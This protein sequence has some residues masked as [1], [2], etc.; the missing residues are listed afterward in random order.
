MA[1]DVKIRHGYKIRGIA[2]NDL[3]A[4]APAVREQYWQ[5]VV[6]L[7]LKRKDKELSEGLDKDGNPLRAIKP[8]TKKHRRSAMTPSRR[9][10]PAAPPL[11]PAFQKSRTRSLLA[12]RAL[13]THAEFFWRFD[14]WTHDSWAVVL[15][16]QAAEGRDV[17]GLSPEGVA[18]VKARADLK[19]SAYK[20]GRLISEPASTTRP[21]E[22]IKG[23]RTPSENAI[24][25]MS[26]GQEP[27]STAGFTKGRTAQEWAAYFR[28]SAKAVVP[29]R[30]VNPPARSGMVGP[31]YN[32]LLQHIWGRRA[33]PKPPGERG[34]SPFSPPR[35]P[36]GPILFGPK[37]KVRTPAPQAGQPFEPALAIAERIAKSP[38]VQRTYR[39]ITK[40][41]S[42]LEKA[43]FAR[44]A[45]QDEMVAFMDARP[46]LRLAPG[47]PET[48]ALLELERKFAEK[49]DRITELRAKAHKRLDQALN[50][51]ASARVR[52]EH[53]DGAG[54]WSKDAVAS[55]T[56]KT[57]QD[58]LATKVANGKAT[59]ALDVQWNLKDG[60]RA[61]ATHTTHTSGP[62]GGPPTWTK[63]FGSITVAPTD[64]AKT[65]VHEMAHHVENST[66]G[67][68][69]AAEEFLAHR[70]GSQKLEKLKDVFPDAGYEDGE[71]GRDDEFAKA[72]GGN[73]RHAYYTGKHYAS[74]QTELISM[75]VERLYDD[76][77]A[78]AE[79]DPE[80]C[81]FILG[82]LDGSLRKP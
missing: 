55:T 61:Y 20:A 47:D 52:W 38:S 68:M 23:G 12:G 34:R 81:K 22:K 80:Y 71:R 65:H 73:R 39:K 82:I 56:R 51:K 14:P 4:H 60:V 45:A 24:F 63:N 50:I 5:W 19:W 32:R 78:F 72:F 41:T 15:S 17:F 28:Q 74:G 69:R 37:P 75:G 1:E 36:I 44:N 54:D 11:T 7:G 64:T 27:G 35:S 76:A 77:S 31:D 57:A 16:Y 48:E 66:P 29:G 58:W 40:T 30:P 6:D 10:D 79:G 43:R 70:V 25:G 59:E 13:S 8:A 21:A 26:V 49:V 18:W 9:G 33:K 42:D 46:H 53:T 67:S 62:V 2:P 3:A